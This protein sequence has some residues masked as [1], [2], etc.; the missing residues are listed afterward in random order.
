MFA[1]HTFTRFAGIGRSAEMNLESNDFKNAA[2]EA[3]QDIYNDVNEVTI[4]NE[5]GQWCYISGGNVN[6][7]RTLSQ[8]RVNQG[9]YSIDIDGTT[10]HFKIC[11]RRKQ[12]FIISPTPKKSAIEEI[13]DLMESVNW[14]THFT[15]YNVSCVGRIRN[16]IGIH[17]GITCSV[18]LHGSNHTD[19]E[20]RIQFYKDFEALRSFKVLSSKNVDADEVVNNLFIHGKK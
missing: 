14:V 17:Y 1:Y 10:Y 12:V 15:R 5:S 13:E 7:I 8:I 18:F 3:C 4:S 2:I 11:P 9:S 19:D 6:A 20:V 16:A